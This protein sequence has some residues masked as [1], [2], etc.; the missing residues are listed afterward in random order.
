[1]DAPPLLPESGAVLG[2]DVGFSPTRRSSAACR[3][4]WDARGITWSLARFRARPEERDAALADLLGPTPLL[5]AALDG[6]LRAELDVIGRYRAAERLL[7]RRL[8]RRIGKPGQSSTPLGRA[9]NAASN[10]C[11]HA[12]LR[13]GRLAP[14]AHA[15]RVHDLA[16]AEA[17][18]SAFLGVMLPEPERLPARRADRSDVFFRH[19]ATPDEATPDG[20]LPAL[21]AFLL[22][23]RRPAPPLVT[24]THHDERAALVCALTALCLAAGHFT[25]A[26]DARD[27]WIILPPRRFVRDWAR[28][29][30]C[31]N[32][33]E[34]PTGSVRWL[35]EG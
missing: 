9:L 16:L 4:A 26:G 5:A 24:V 7:T 2:L 14:A 20:T 31:T 10:D 22:P 17:F 28:E 34:D 32:A 23:G 12:V 8:G 3:L 11:A 18:P 21:L 6:P 13:L 25:T 30:L 19:L 29:A 15:E 1:M 35:P 27:G 33:H